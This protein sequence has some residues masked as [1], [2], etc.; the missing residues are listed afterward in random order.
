MSF[1]EFIKDSLPE[2]D[3]SRFPA[4]PF[5]GQRSFFPVDAFPSGGED[6]RSS[7]S[8]SECHEEEKGKMPTQE[9]GIF[10]GCDHG[11]DLILGEN[12]MADLLML[13]DSSAFEG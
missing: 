2:A 1:Q 10:G 3:L 5:H 12:D 6:F 8:A 11:R 7:Q 13:G 9:G 4:L